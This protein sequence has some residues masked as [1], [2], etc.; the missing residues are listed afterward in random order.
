MILDTVFVV[1]AYRENLSSMLV[2]VS[3][4]IFLIH[5]LFVHLLGVFLCY[6]SSGIFLLPMKD[7]SLN[8]EGLVVTTAERAGEYYRI[9]HFSIR[10][11]HEEY[12]KLL[13]ALE[14]QEIILI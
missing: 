8:I 9:G 1:I 7:A 11:T 2:L 4:N 12:C 5:L 13:E 10:K 3:S 6:K 14:E